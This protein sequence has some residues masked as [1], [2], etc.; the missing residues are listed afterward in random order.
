MEEPLCTFEK[1]SI[2]KVVCEEMASQKAP[3][4]G[5]VNSVSELLLQYDPVYR[6]TWRFILKFLALLGEVNSKVR[7]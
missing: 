4:D 5:I 3:F 7:T 2:F 6:D 1:Y